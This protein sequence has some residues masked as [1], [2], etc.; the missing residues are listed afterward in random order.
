V[1]T[2]VQQQRGIKNGDLVRVFNGRGELRIAAKV[3]PRIMPGVSAMGQ[4]VFGIS[5][6]TVFASLI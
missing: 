3:T 6:L 1:V 2:S 4:G 5:Y